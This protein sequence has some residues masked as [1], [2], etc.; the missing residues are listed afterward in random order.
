MTRDAGSAPGTPPHAPPLHVLR[1]ADHRR[2]PWKNGL[3]VTLEIARAERAP[4]PPASGAQAPSDFIWR[5]SIADVATDG[6]FSTFPEIDRHLML[7][8][9]RGVRLVID[10]APRTLDRLYEP[11]EFAGESSTDCTLLD[12]PVRDF[13]VMVDRRHAAASVRRLEHGGAHRLGPDAL[14]F[15]VAFGGGG[16]VAVVVPA[17]EPEGSG[18]AEGTAPAIELHAGDA[19][20]MPA[21]SAVMATLLDAGGALVEVVIRSVDG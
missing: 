6:P 1:A 18:V 20:R 4:A 11:V 19:V 8:Q 7:I 2:M 16:V 3:G 10:G 14:R 21:S 5:L 12:G 13:N 9:G 15:V 17:D